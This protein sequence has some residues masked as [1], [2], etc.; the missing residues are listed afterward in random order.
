MKMII[1]GIHEFLKTIIR[2]NRYLSPILTIQRVHHGHDPE[3]LP[4]F[5]NFI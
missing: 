4:F 3:P 5:L 2:K 1:T